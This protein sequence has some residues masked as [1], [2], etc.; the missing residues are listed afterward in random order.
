MLFT[1]RFGWAVAKKIDF[2]LG[3]FEK[4]PRYTMERNYS[5][6]IKA[7]VPIHLRLL[8]V[9]LV[10]ALLPIYDNFKEK[11][12]ISCPDPFATP[13]FQSLMKLSDEEMQTFIKMSQAWRAHTMN[14]GNFHQF[15]IGLLEGWKNLRQGHPTKLDIMCLVNKMIAELKNNENT[16]NVDSKKSVHEKLVKAIKDGWDAYLV[17]INGDVKDEILDNGIHQMS[18]KSFYAKVTGI[19]TFYDDLVATTNWL[20]ANHATYEDLLLACSITEDELVDPPVPNDELDDLSDNQLKN[21]IRSI[22]LSTSTKLKL[23][24]KKP[25]LIERIKKHREGIA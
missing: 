1:F 23:T 25:D 6:R 2:T 17:I 8:L 3:R 22:N 18:G 12:H 19:S 5:D 10:K 7:N 21:M 14:W 16:M 4:V 20:I 13:S 15:F 9:S 11:E 24:G